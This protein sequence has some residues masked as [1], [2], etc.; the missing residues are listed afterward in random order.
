MIC[1]FIAFYIKRNQK[2]SGVNLI[3][4]LRFFENFYKDARKE[5][6]NLTEDQFVHQILE[7]WDENVNEVI[8]NRLKLKIINKFLVLD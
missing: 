3:A 1:D 4:F 8:N 2:L 5:N 7:K 6:P